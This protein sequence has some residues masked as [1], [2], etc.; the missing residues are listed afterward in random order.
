[1]KLLIALYHPFALW[2]SPPWFAERL[3]ADFPAVSVVQLPGPKYE[4]LE[5]ELSD[6]D[7]AIAFSIRPE[8]FASARRLKWVHSP[9]AAVH[10]LMF[11]E[12]ISSEVIVTNA[13]N[14]HGS[15][16]AEHALALM[17]ALARRLPSAVRYQQQKV[18]AQKQLWEEQPPPRELAGSTVCVVGMGSIG[19]EFTRRALAL[20]MRV[21]AV[22]EHPERG[23]EGTSEVTGTADLDRVLPGADFVVLA[24]PLT[25]ATQNLIS[26]DRLARMRKEAYL[27]NVSRGPLIDD[28]ALI[29][30]LRGRRIA[31][32]A[33]DVF[34]E[35]PLPPDS[36]YWGFDNVLI[37]P[38]T[39]AVTEKL[40]ERHY[41]VVRENLARFLR[42]EPLLYV[43]DKRKGY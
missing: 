26:A 36:P 27:I 17:F 40:W 13:R 12:M 43:V 8:Q 35:E 14:V 30:A 32:A 42:G 25:P 23:G 37:T 10:Q 24:V 6:A 15:V 39:A 41:Q 34:A 1:L 38:H 18:W 9:A 31:G 7:I 20:G 2:T 21:I 5:R 11:P 33:L 29:S 3:R 16:V 22:R 19:R 28:P 4:G